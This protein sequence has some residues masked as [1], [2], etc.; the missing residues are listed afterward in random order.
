MTNALWVLLHTDFM[1]RTGAWHTKPNVFKII[2]NSQIKIDQYKQTN[3]NRNIFP[4][5]W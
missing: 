3:E 2:K 5:Y 4:D 1:F